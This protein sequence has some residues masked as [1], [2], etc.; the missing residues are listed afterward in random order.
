MNLIKTVFL[1]FG[2]V[3]FSSHVFSQ[4]LEEIDN[5]FKQSNKIKENDSYINIYLNSNDCFR[6]FGQIYQ[7]LTTI[8][9]ENKEI[10]INI[11]TN[12]IVFAKKNTKDYTFDINFYLDKDIVQ[13]YPSFYYYKLNKQIISDNNQIINEIKKNTP[14]NKITLIQLIDESFTSDNLVHA[15]I[16]DNFIIVYDNTVDLGGIIE[17]SKIEYYD[18]TTSSKKL[19]NQLPLPY[20]NYKEN[21]KPLSYEDFQNIKKNF[22]GVPDIKVT[23]I[24]IFE[25]IAYA[26]FMVSRVFQSTQDST[27]FE[28]PSFTYLAIK[29]LK[30]NNLKDIFDLNSYDNYFCMDILPFNSIDYRIGVS[31]NYPF[32]IINEHNFMAKIF[33]ELDY[34]G[35]ATFEFNEDY[36]TLN[37]TSINPEAPRIYEYENI[38]IDG[39]KYYVDKEMTDESTGEGIISLKERVMQND[40]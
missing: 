24:S 18:I 16:Y 30:N 32:T 2:V 19:Y 12:E 20:K 40:N 26:G 23:S 25:D 33:N 39:K 8:E 38:E 37:I 17:N 22:P 10:Q 9:E 13:K 34:A 21:F 1:L 15:G 27:A 29:K 31:I 28:L 6:C 3:V 36:T 4:N 7:I 5:H 35:E 14:K 11:I